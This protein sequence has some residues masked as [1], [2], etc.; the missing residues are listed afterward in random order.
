MRLYSLIRVRNCCHNIYMLQTILVKDLFEW[1]DVK[2]GIVWTY[3]IHSSKHSYNRFLSLGASQRTSI[4]CVIVFFY[5]SKSQS[6]RWLSTCLR[7]IWY[8]LKGVHHVVA[9]I[10]FKSI[11]CTKRA[12]TFFSNR[13]TKKM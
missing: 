7:Y 11:V 13:L 1:R 9:S 12:M 6:V 4:Y 10:F 8:F 3:F 2:L 5:I